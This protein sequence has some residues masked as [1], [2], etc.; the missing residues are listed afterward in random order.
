[1]SDVFD[2]VQWKAAAVN[3][4]QFLMILLFIAST[5][6][7]DKD[8]VYGPSW[9]EAGQGHMTYDGYGGWFR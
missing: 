9:I 4:M 3:G 5:T 6:C 7:C 8:Y 1:M 2:S